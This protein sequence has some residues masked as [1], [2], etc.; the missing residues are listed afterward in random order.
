MKTI[1]LLKICNKEKNLKSTDRRDMLH[2]EE[3]RKD[4]S[5]SLVRNNASKNIVK[6]HL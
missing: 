2:I 1:R 6:Q 3:Q 4:D 5:R